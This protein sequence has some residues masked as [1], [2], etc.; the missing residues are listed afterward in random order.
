MGARS[1]RNSRILRTRNFRD[2]EA[3]PKQCQRRSVNFGTSYLDVSA[4][5]GAEASS[6][7]IS[8]KSGGTKSLGA[9]LGR[10]WD[11]RLA[12]RLWLRGQQGIPRFGAAWGGSKAFF[13]KNKE[14][15]PALGRV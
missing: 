5:G 9:S 4:S 7:H 8:T 1:G 3:P 13:F 6:V 11:V 2:V 14:N 10:C 15:N 12:L